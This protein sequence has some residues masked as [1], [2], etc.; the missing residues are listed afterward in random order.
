[1]PRPSLR[2]TLLGAVLVVALVAGLVA[3]LPTGALDGVG[4]PPAGGES[5]RQRPLPGPE[6]GLLWKADASRPIHREW[7]N[8]STEDLCFEDVPDTLTAPGRSS[9]RVRQ[10]ADLAPPGLARSYLFQL[11]D[12]DDCAGERVEIGQANPP[13]P[14]FEDRVFHRGDEVWIGY[15]F[16]IPSGR[17]PTSSTW[18]CLMQIKGEGQGGPLFCPSVLDERLELGT[19]SSRDQLSVG[20]YPLWRHDRPLHRDRWIKML[21]HIRFDPDPQVGFVEFYADL[22]DGEGMRL[23]VPR[24]S[25]F[26]M[27]VRSDGTPTP[28]HARIGIYRD[29]HVVGDAE[30]Y[31]AGFTVARTREVVERYAFPGATAEGS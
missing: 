4:D 23:R 22:A 17:F 2:S 14:G 6:E 29:R 27:K 9:T 21:L 28:V 30:M 8:Y 10:T 11:R 26:T 13:K 3:A 5:P 15:Q 20:G 18:N 16:L 7:A 19:I 12:G 24:R 31:Y 25:L 1:M